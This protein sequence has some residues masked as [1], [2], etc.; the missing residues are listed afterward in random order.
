MARKH[1]EVRRQETGRVDAGECLVQR[2]FL[3]SNFEREEMFPSHGKRM[4]WIGYALAQVQQKATILRIQAGQE[5]SG[6]LGREVGDASLR[7]GQ[8]RIVGLLDVANEPTVE[9]LDAG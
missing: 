1:I 2:P 5:M 8:V 7:F 4:G 9:A 3:R 6:I